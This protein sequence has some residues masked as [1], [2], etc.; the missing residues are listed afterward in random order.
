MPGTHRPLRVRL[1]E[2][3]RAVLADYQRACFNV[4]EK[5]GCEFQRYFGDGILFYFGYPNA[6]EDEGLRAVR[7]A[8]GIIDAMHDLNVRLEAER[9]MSLVARLSI[10]TGL[11]V[12]GDIASGE[13]LE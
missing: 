9:G 12:A 2:D 8:L 3:L 13:P 7:S 5:Y 1:G 4:V 10:H 11:V 6:H